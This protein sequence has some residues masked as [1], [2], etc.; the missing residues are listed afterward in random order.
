VAAHSRGEDGRSESSP[1][2]HCF[3]PEWE[4]NRAIERQIAAFDFEGVAKRAI[5][6]G[7]DRACGRI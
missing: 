5:A 3:T 2:G 7:I 6:N 1:A 4:I